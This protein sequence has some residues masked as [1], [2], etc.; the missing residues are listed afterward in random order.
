MKKQLKF[1][2][3]RHTLLAPTRASCQATWSLHYHRF[4]VKGEADNPI[5][6]TVLPHDIFQHWVWFLEEREKYRRIFAC[7]ASDNVQD[8]VAAFTVS[9]CSYNIKVLLD[10][11]KI[12]FP[13]SPF[14]FWTMSYYRDV[15]GR[16][17]A[18]L[19]RSPMFLL[20]AK[21]VKLEMAKFMFRFSEGEKLDNSR[22]LGHY[23][24]LD[25]EVKLDH[26]DQL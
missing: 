8:D 24:V 22:K 12:A 3:A 20:W 25:N 1:S 15:D 4:T 9:A 5:V 13:T 2:K 21:W 11:S 17:A 19:P 16:M 6:N 26:K 14:Y 7:F 18:A 10:A 23:M